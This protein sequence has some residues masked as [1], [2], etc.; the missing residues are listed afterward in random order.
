MERTAIK[1]LVLTTVLVAAVG[2]FFPLSTVLAQSEKNGQDGKIVL[3][4][5][6]ALKGPTSFLGTEMNKGADAY[7]AKYAPEIELMAI[8]DRYE[9]VKC[10]VNTNRFIKKKVAALFAYVGTPT[11]KVAVP[12][13]TKQGMIFFG[14]FTGAGFLSDYNLNP[15]S[16]SVRA[17][18][19]AELDNM[20]HRLKKDL[21]VKTI[22]LFVQRDAFGLVGVKGVL[23]AVKKHG[24]EIVPKVPDIPGD[25]ASGA[26]WKKFW[27]HVPNYK[28]NTVAV[29]RSARKIMGV[30]AD[31]VI[32]VGTYR[33]CATAINLWKRLGYDAVFINI[34]FV[35]SK[36]LANRLK[37]H[38]NVYISQVV[39]N[40]WD[41]SIPI[42]N[43][44]QKT[45]DRREYGFVS[46]EGYIAAKI[47]HE[48]IKK[49]GKP[50]NANGLKQAIESLS[51]YDIGGLKASFGPKDHRG[52][53][54]IY[55]TRIKSDS[56]NQI[57]FK[58]I[59]RLFKE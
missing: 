15:H 38:K 59:N 16:F 2:F 12:L 3:G 42:V 24:V 37:D 31:A 19:D 14:A 27:N 49:A 57:S 44:Y 1:F 40:P 25:D 36:D 48:A 4:Q 47:M 53:D 7:L 56:K 11:S 13:A 29:G 23:K 54:A 55:L 28:R 6:C 32:L 33:P 21:N 43:E 9:P 22:S 35:G 26:E 45:L 20:V 8:D 34:S 5:S 41:S 46:L 10:I 18:Y 51:N 30:R 52:L 58:Y 17:S 39:P 50:I